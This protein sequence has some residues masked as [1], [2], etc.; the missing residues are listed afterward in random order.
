M[1]NMEKIRASKT[2][3]LD[4]YLGVDVIIIGTSF[5]TFRTAGII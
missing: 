5:S 3:R 1:T 2:L 4:S